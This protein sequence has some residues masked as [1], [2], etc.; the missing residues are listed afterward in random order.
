VARDVH[1]LIKIPAF[2]GMTEGRSRN[3][4]REEQEWRREEQEWRREEQE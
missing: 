2:A 3:D 1:I 4:G